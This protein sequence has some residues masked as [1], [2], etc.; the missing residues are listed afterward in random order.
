MPLQIATMLLER[1]A[2]PLASRGSSADGEGAM[3]SPPRVCTTERRTRRS[4]AAEGQGAQQHA[5]DDAEDG[6]GGADAERQRQHRT[7]VKPGLF[8]SCAAGEPEILPRAR[9][10]LSIHFIC[11]SFAGVGR[12]AD[13]RVSSRS[14]KRLRAS[15]R[16][17][18]WGQPAVDQ[19]ARP[20]CPD[21]SELL[22]DVHRLPG[23]RCAGGSWKERR[24]GMASGGLQ[25][26]GDGLDVG[27]PG[28]Q[29]RLQRLPPL[30]GQL[31]ELGP[32]VVL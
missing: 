4:G 32:A 12:A 19:L 26:L 1:A 18:S 13:F 17:S 28:R 8:Q 22:L 10:S 11:L 31:V 20:P 30:V 15:T 27:A 2:R 14:P 23:W 29:L 24:R 3:R 9:P 6:R 25:H 5:V 16:A 7:R 21:G